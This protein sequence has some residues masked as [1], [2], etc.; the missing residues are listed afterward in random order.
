MPVL[1]A[2][3]GFVVFLCLFGMRGLKIA[4]AVFG[5]GVG[6]FALYV[7]VIVLNMPPPRN[8]AFHATKPL[9][10]VAAG[11]PVA[12]VATCASEYA[13]NTHARRWCEENAIGD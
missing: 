10:E 12:P 1:I 4:G 2:L 13:P 6:L 5:V 11:P 7:A 3:A 9:A 8:A